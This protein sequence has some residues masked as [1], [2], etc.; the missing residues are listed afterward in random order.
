MTRYEEY[1]QRKQREFGDKFDTSDLAPEFIEYFNSGE[2]IEVEFRSKLTREV[3]ET[4]RGTIGVTT[5][6]K[7]AFILMLRKT[8]RGSSHLLSS[9]DVPRRY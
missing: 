9:S 4:K 3:Y 7:P 2:R 6:W 8:S 5:G 1:I